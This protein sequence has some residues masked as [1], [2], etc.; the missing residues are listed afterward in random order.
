MNKIASFIGSILPSKG[1]LLLALA[2]LLLISYLSYSLRTALV[3]EGEYTQTIIQLQ[4]TISE[5]NLETERLLVEREL[6][7]N[8]VIVVEKE[9]SKMVC[10]GSVLVQ[11]IKN[12]P[13]NKQSNKITKETTS[14]GIANIDDKLPDSLI[15]ILD[16]LHE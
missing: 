16:K 6:E 3:K 4:S 11:E 5:M 15:S 9:V 14:D 7:L 1:V 8:N 2:T 12:I 13:N 10:E